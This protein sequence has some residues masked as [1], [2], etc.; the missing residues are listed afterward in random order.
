MKH[1]SAGIRGLHEHKDARRPLDR[2]VDKGLEAVVAEI[3]ADGQGIRSPG[4]L[5]PEVALGVGRGRR[6]DIVP[7]AVEDDQQT[8]P[9]RVIDDLG[10]GGHSQRTELLEERRL[11]LDRRHERGDNVDH[12]AAEPA[13]G[14]RQGLQV[15]LGLRGRETGRQHVGPR[16]E[17]DQDGVSTSSHS[18]LQAVRECEQGW[19]SLI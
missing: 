14:R 10:Q 4:A 16:V 7:L 3:R 11:R 6:A 13:V 19:D 8:L 1:A 17:P 5:P 18:R 15:G 2:H 12:L 9:S